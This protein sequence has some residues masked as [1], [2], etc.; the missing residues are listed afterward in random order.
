[1]HFKYRL[2]ISFLLVALIPIGIIGE[3]SIISSTKALTNKSLEELEKNTNL[4]AEKIENYLNNC[5]SDVLFLSKSPKVLKYSETKHPFDRW[6]LEFSLLSLSLDK[7]YHEVGYLDE[8]T[9]IYVKNKKIPEERNTENI[10][11]PDLKQGEV[12]VSDIFLKRNN[13]IFE[14]PYQP[15]I[16][17]AAP[18]YINEE[19]KGYVYLEAYLT[20]FISDFESSTPR[21]YFTDS[22]GNYIYHPDPLKRW[23]AELD[24]KENLHKD[25]NNLVDDILSGN[26][27]ASISGDEIV[28]YVP[29]KIEDKKW[30][31]I[32]SS[33]KDIILESVRRFKLGFYIVVSTVLVSATAI[34]Y[35]LSKVIT[36]PLVNLT[37]ATE[38]IAEGDLRTKI[39]ETGSDELKILAR[40]FNTMAEKLNE[41]YSALEKKVEE[42]T[43]ELKLINEKLKASYKELVEANKTKSR[44]LA[45]ISHELKTPLNSIIGFTEVMLDDENLNEEQRDYLQTILRNSDNLLYM[46]E[47][48]LTISRIEAGKSEMIFT[49]FKISEVFEKSIKI[50]E[51]LAK[52]KCIEIST[53]LKYDPVIR[54][55]MRK[56]MQVMLNLL[57]NAIKFNRENGK[58]YLRAMKAGSNL[59]VEVEDTGIGIKEEYQGIIFDEFKQVGDLETKEYTGT[60]L[61]LA[62]TR[63]FIEMH[64]GRIW[65]E[66]EYG[67]GSKFIFEIPVGDLNGKK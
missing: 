66:S 59:R 65:V 6:D 50:V 52:D 38:K 41:S 51:P 2:L 22:S 4:E 18:I 9:I 67:K 46:I 45:N 62:I 10:N 30:F 31:L 49:D 15:L 28:S 29:I 48:L 54:G 3:Y 37:K 47:D 57:S 12:Y 23:S 19:R 14:I 5:R 55:D 25:Y 8:N 63:N 17:F 24:G 27:G 32:M 44:F 60:G 39:S 58:I 53:E 33:P 34:S 64:N 43:A 26:S 35:F 7:N 36:E 42:R 56:I 16:L 61:G 21:V 11:I 1:M 20:E 13:G 40:S